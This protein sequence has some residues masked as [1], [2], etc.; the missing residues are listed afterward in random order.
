MSNLIK[1]LLTHRERPTLGVLLGL[2]VGA[3]LGLYPFQRS[4]TPTIGEVLKGQ[5]VV[6]L[7]EVGESE[8]ADVVELVAVMD[9]GEELERE[10]WRTDVFTP[11]AGQVGLAV[12]LVVAGFG[13]TM[14]IA[15]LGREKG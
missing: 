6:E 13:V 11:S 2:L 15:R 9:T 8:D 4:V 12:V 1:W 5:T 10:D 14:G 7:R 3:V